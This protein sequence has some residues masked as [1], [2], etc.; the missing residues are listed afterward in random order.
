MKITKT[1]L[2]VEQNYTSENS[3][4]LNIHK[5]EVA[6]ALVQQNNLFDFDKS[7]F[8]PESFTEIIKL[9]RLM[10]NYYLNPFFV[11]PAGWDR[12]TTGDKL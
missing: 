11:N 4:A 7:D 12:Q 10:T 2:P 9:L 1:I 6:Y 8:L 5:I 3:D